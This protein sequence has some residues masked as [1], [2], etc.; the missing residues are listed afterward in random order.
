MNVRVYVFPGWGLVV[1]EPYEKVDTNGV[2]LTVAWENGRRKS[3]YLARATGRLSILSL[4]KEEHDGVA[5]SCQD[6]VVLKH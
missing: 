2:G 3:P 1:F 6:H 5:R 4:N